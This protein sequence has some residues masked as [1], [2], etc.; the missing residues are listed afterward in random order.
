MPIEHARHM[1]LGQLI[2][3]LKAMPANEQV[4][5]D[6]VH[7]APTTL[8]SYRGYYEDLAIG[9]A[10]LSDHDVKEMTVAE[11]LALLEK[12]IGQTFKGY[13][14]GDYVARRTTAL[15]VANLGETGSTAI[16]GVHRLSWT[17]MIETGN[18]D[19]AEA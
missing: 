17:V 19:L 1:T 2:D 7:M 15:W 3:A 10:N 11:L 16:V 13:K 9:Y 18:A 12:A 8:H 4:R 5:F 6:F 14:G